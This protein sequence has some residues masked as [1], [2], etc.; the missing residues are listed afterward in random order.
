[1]SCNHLH[2][3][4]CGTSL[5]FFFFDLLSNP[6][7]FLS[8]GQDQFLDGIEEVFNVQNED[9]EDEDAVARGEN[10]VEEHHDLENAS[11]GKRV[12]RKRPEWQG[13]I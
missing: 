4:S 3:L 11:R 2:K 8:D 7:N 13:H 1:M 12:G 5:P 10:Y 6:V 9:S